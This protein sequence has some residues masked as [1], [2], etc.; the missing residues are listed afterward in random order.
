MIILACLCLICSAPPEGEPRE[1]KARVCVRGPGSQQVPGKYLQTDG[2]ASGSQ[3]T[4]G[5]SRRQFPALPSK[6]F[7]LEVLLF[8]C[9]ELE[10]GLEVKEAV[11]SNLQDFFIS[12]VS[13]GLCS[14]SWGS[15]SAPSCQCHLCIRVTK[16]Q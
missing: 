4:L 10:C 12:H 11:F 14:C 15:Q 16:T 1:G 9:L 8:F 3:A 5:K 6:E 7:K 13:F 2:A